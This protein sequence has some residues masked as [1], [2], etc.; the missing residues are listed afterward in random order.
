M[1]I[2]L[3]AQ[4]PFLQSRS[5]R[6]ARF[7]ALYVMV[8]PRE[9]AAKVCSEKCSDFV[10]PALRGQNSL[11]RKARR[12]RCGMPSPSRAGLPDSDPGFHGHARPQEVLW[13]LALLEGDFHRDSLHHLDIVP[14]GIF[15]WQ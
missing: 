7:I 4:I 9:F 3:G 1:L 13:V 8:E 14:S 2:S 6:R 10:H 12:V 5:L 15:G 11:A